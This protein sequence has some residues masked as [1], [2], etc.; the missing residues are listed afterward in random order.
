MRHA[1]VTKTSVYSG[2]A[3]RTCEHVTE[4]CFIGRTAAVKFYFF[5]LLSSSGVLINEPM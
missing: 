4:I 3:H 1:G 5:S 2:L